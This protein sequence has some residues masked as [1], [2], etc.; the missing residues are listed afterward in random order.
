LPE[1]VATDLLDAIAE[2]RAEDITDGEF[3]DICPTAYDGAEV[4][5]T[6]PLDGGREIASCEWNI[7]TEHEL[8]KAAVRARAEIGTVD[9]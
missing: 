2:T 1:A 8:V 6:F 5:Y 4:V 7:D 9:R 3:D